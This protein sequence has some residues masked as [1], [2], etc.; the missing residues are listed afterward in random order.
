MALAA[1]LAIDED[2]LICDMA[3]VYHVTDIR[4]LPVKTLAVLACGLPAD[5]RIRAALRESS[6]ARAENNDTGEI[7][8]FDGG[9][10]FDAALRAFEEGGT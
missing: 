8:G 3:Q 9:E 1:M 4:A 6:A 10:D 7:Q 5:A 2:A